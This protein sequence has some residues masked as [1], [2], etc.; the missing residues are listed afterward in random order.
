V[1]AEGRLV[2]MVGGGAQAV[3]TGVLGPADL[4]LQLMGRPR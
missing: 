2:V 1:A 4:A 3:P